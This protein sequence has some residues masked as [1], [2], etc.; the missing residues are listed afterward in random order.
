MVFSWMVGWMVGWLDGWLDGWL[1]VQATWS[2]APRSRD[3]VP[4]RNTSFRP[5]ELG[6]KR[7]MHVTD[8]GPPD[9]DSST[10]VLWKV[11][12]TGAH[13]LTAEPPLASARIEWQKYPETSL[14]GVTEM[15]LNES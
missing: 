13:P 3:V 10:E 2:E 5:V 8:R 1:I 6:I 15:W 12:P 11:R 9:A 14:G 7:P 4:S